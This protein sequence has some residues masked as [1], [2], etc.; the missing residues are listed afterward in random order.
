MRLREVKAALGALQHAS[1]ASLE[2]LFAEHVDLCSYRLDAWRMG[3]VNHRLAQQR[4]RHRRGVYLGGYGYLVDVRPGTRKLTTVAPPTARRGPLLEDPANGGHIHAPSINHA[5]AAAVMRNAYLTH[6]TQNAPDLMSVKLSSAR[7][8]NAL[9]IVQ[10]I[11][12]GQTLSELLGYQF[13]RGLHDGHLTGAELEPLVLALRRH[14]PLVANRHVQTRT[15]VGRAHAAAARNVIDGLAVVERVRKT[16]VASYPFGFTGPDGLPQASQAQR[17]AIDA[18]VQRLLDTSDAVADLMTAESVYQV[19]QGQTERAGVAADTI[20][21]GARPHDL[22]VI[23]TP[24]SGTLLVHRV[25]L[26][27]DAASPPSIATPRALAE[28]AID[29][30]LVDRIPAPDEIACAV[31]WTDPVSGSHAAIVTQTMLGLAATDL[32]QLATLDGGELDERIEQHVRSMAS[33]HPGLVIAL[34]YTRPIPGKV[35]LFELAALIRELRSIV[36]ESRP[37][38]AFDLVRAADAGGPRWD[39]GELAARIETAIGSL[40]A[41]GM[42]LAGDPGSSAEELLDR[43]AARFLAIGLH[44]IP[45]TGTASFRSRI[46]E[47]YEQAM[48]KVRRVVERWEQL[49]ISESDRPAFEATKVALRELLTMPA[50][51]LEVWL[52]EAEPVISLIATFDPVWFDIPREA[53]DLMPERRGLALIATDLQA[54]V[55][56]VQADLAARVADARDQVARARATADPAAA[57]MLLEQAARRV[58]GGSC[59][60]LPRFTIDVD[61]G[62]ELRS[63]RDGVATLLSAL[64]REFPVEDWLAGIARVRG[65]LAH[66]ESM[67]ALSEAFDRSP[68]PLVPIQ[69]PF[70]DDDRWAALEL[71]AS[72]EL[73]DEKLLYTASFARPFDETQPQCGLV[74]DEWT[75]VIP[76]KDQTT[77]IAFH[78][79]QPNTEPPQALLLATP[80]AFTGAW[81]WNDLVDT[82]VETFEEAKLRAIEPSQIAASVYGQVLPAAL[83]VVT[84]SRITLSTNL[85][86]NGK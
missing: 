18:E 35:S 1:T 20:G 76:A 45:Q 7:V 63:A 52:S 10:G 68:V 32:L 65:K 6:A 74:V 2:R 75:E 37:L 58:L 23:R 70:V 15:P 3:L 79:D 66:W 64:D 19:V 59:K 73:D 16:G 17:T 44:G 55:A 54:R 46:R 57:F 77:G 31:E 48:T 14:F 83:F 50:P 4:Q 38:A 43:V 39:L 40:E 28:P 25:A 56:A 62:A 22:D 86:D 21:S 34:H 71:P 47:L 24:R 13:E 12:R 60:L 26:Q 49:T 61:A 11:Q 67:A 5:T 69:L 72:Y 30:W 51:T 8:R 9:S 27:L 80:P 81:K 85:A 82:V 78:F 53:N 36:L 29:A 41:Q 84:R 42:L 33:A